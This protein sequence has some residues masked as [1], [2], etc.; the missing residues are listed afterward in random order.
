[1]SAGQVKVHDLLRKIDHAQAQR[2]R[3]Q[4]LYRCPKAEDVHAGFFQCLE[5]QRQREPTFV[6]GRSGSGDLA[7]DAVP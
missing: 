5:R 6:V 1:M 4:N 7:T 2:L 3:L